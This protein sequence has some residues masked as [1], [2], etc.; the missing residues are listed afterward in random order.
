MEGLSGAQFALPGAV[1]RLRA[2]RPDPDAVAPAGPAEVRVLAAV[3]PANPYGALVP[4][5]APAAGCEAR[6]RRSPELWQRDRSQHGGLR[7]VGAM[8]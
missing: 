7:W 4:W 8:R 1:E 3:D 2:V 5:P 6:P